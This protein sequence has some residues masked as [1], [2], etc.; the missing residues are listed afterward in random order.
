[1]EGI[2]QV[3]TLLT[4]MAV[5]VLNGVVNA[6]TRRRD[7]HHRRIAAFEALPGII[8]ESI[9]ASRP[10]HFSFGSAA[11]GTES[12][13]L[14]LASAEFA[15]YTAQLLTISDTS[16]LFTVTETAAVPLAVDT[17][18]LAYQSRGL[19]AEHF[20][21]VNIRWYPAGAQSLAFAGGITAMQSEEKLAANFLSGSFGTEIALILDMSQRKQRPTLAVSD[22]LE[23]QA[24][25]YAL[26]DYPLIGEEIFAAGAYVSGQPRLRRRNA[27]L[28]VGRW[29]LVIILLVIVAANLI[30][31]FTGA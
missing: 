29:L 16:P 19:L 18:R 8:G 3:G 15:Y 7:L 26:A 4:I 14:A 20:K 2:L 13:L 25:S 31:L 23:G 6:L 22:R 27:V 9:E 28:D 12:T 30:R 1:M 11:P 17:L 24:V 5:F 21:P 10:V